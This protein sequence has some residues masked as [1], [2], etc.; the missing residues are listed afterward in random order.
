MVVALELNPGTVSPGA[1]KERIEDHIR[2][3]A[4]LDLRS[5]EHLLGMRVKV[6]DEIFADDERVR[7]GAEIPLQVVQ[8]LACFRVAEMKRQVHVLAGKEL[9]PRERQF[10]FYSVHDL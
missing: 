9:G 7:E 5:F 6:L 8:R 3:A 1:R 10:D 4:R 2:P